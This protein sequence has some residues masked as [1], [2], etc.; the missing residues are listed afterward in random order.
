MTVENGVRNVLKNK[1]DIINNLRLQIE[2]YQARITSLEKLIEKQR[3]VS[4]SA[5]TQ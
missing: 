1:E 5:S 4:L 2:D 3:Q